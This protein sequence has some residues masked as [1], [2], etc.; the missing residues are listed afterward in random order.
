VFLHAHPDDEA[1]LTAGT[2]ARAVAGGDRVVLVMA[3]DGEAGLTARSETGQLGAR[4]RTELAASAAAIGIARVER[5]GCRDSGLRGTHPDGFAHLDPADLARRLAAILDE[6][7]AQVLVGYDA[8]GGY[9]HPDHVQVHRVARLA[10]TLAARPPQLFE[11]T[12][13]REP[14]VRAVHLAARLRLTPRAFDPGEFDLAWT[15][16]RDITHHVDVRAHLGAKRAALAAHHSQAT[17]DGGPPR[18][19]A[20]LT[21]LPRPVQRW[22]LGTEYFTLVSPSVAVPRPRSAPPERSL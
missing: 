21:S 1:L 11:V 16:R 9:G 4:R 10:A 18:T 14:I 22:L 3:T 12:L 6:E 13:P 5:L 8:R 17:A 7:G 15:P 19:L 2:M 20:L